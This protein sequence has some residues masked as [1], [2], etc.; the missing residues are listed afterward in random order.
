MTGGKTTRRISSNPLGVGP[1]GSR[2]LRHVAGGRAGGFWSRHTRTARRC[3]RGR[4]Q[5]PHPRAVHRLGSLGWTDAADHTRRGR[6]RLSRSDAADHVSNRGMP[7]PTV[8]SR[9]GRGRSRRPADRH[10]RRS[11]GPRTPSRP[12]VSSRIASHSSGGSA[13]RS[14]AKSPRKKIS[15]RVEMLVRSSRAEELHAAEFAQQI[16]QFELELARAALPE[17]WQR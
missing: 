9:R 13:S 4:R 1:R 5:H 12:A 3:G 8:R 16:A 15:E 6:S 14:S 7:P 10:A 17:E 2:R 11:R